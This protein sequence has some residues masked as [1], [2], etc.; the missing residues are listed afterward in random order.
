MNS[1]THQSSKVWDLRQHAQK[2]PSQLAVSCGD[3]H[4]TYGELETLANQIAALFRSF[5]LVRGD[6]IALLIGNRPEILAVVWG[7][8]RAG[9][10]ITPIPTALTLTEIT[11]MVT[12][13]DAKMVLVDAALGESS[14]NIAKQL[15]SDT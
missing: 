13:C 2:S 15:A 8:W 9:L 3:V 6:H 11:Y 4:Y 1:S 5:G 14:E 12:D 10:Y 7:A